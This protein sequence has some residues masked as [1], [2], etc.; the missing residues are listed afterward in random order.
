MNLQVKG[1]LLKVT[2]NEEGNL[3][4]TLVFSLLILILSMYAT[5]PSGFISSHNTAI[6]IRTE[7]NIQLV[8]YN[9]IA[10]LNNP[11]I[12]QQTFSSA[13]NTTLTPC[14]TDSTFDCPKAALPL[15]ITDEKGLPYYDASD[16]HTG[17]DKY[18]NFCSTFNR[19]VEGLC[20]FQFQITWTPQCPAVGSCYS[21][22]ILVNFTLIAHGDNQSVQIN[23]VRY[24]YLMRLN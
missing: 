19:L 14:F 3:A 8:E 1:H 13:L 15:V 9:L 2:Q 18:G 17:F 21:P 23:P 6:Q 10:Y 22:P 24:G 4:I 5:L 7:T 20:Q 16:P 11:L 12:W